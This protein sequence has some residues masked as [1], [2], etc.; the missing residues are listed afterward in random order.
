VWDSFTGKATT[1]WERYGEGK[2]RKRRLKIEDGRLKIEDRIVGGGLQG[3]RI[4][5]AN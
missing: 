1:N 2:R 3:Y 4:M 5:H